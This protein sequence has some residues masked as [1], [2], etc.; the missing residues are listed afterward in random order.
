MKK[1]RLFA[2]LGGC[3]ALS[4][5]L[6]L[7]VSA[8]G[9][10]LLR[11]YDVDCNGTVNVLDLIYLKSYLL[12]P[13]SDNQGEKLPDEEPEVKPGKDYIISKD[14]IDAINKITAD[15]I[16][17]EKKWLIDPAKMP[18]DLSKVEHVIEIEQTYLCFSPEMRV[19]NYDN[20]NSFEFTVKSNMTSD[21]MIRDETNIDITRDEYM[22]LIR[23]KE[24]NSINKT[25]YQFLYSGE[26]IAIDI[27][28]GDLDGLAYMEI[29]FANKQDADS[30][31]TPEW[32]I[33]D[34]TADVRYK[35]GHLARYGIPE[36]N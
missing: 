16:E 31:E 21:G 5:A 35:N 17:I 13:Q 28:H 27:F 12:T 34:V 26:V 9:A 36:R 18:Y 20:G 33:A 8:S 23:K 24:G 1:S 19:R 29:E 25:R 11:S 3:L 10:E 6:F 2:A 4:F 22:D 32:V 14:Y 7:N 15:D 30:F